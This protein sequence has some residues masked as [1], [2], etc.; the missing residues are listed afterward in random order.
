MLAHGGDRLAQVARPIEIVI[1]D[2]G[3]DVATGDGDCLVQTGAQ[4]YLHAELQNDPAAGL[5]QALHTGRKQTAPQAVQDQ[6]DL[7]RAV[8]LAVD[9]VQNVRQEACA[10]GDEDNADEGAG[11]HAA[12]VPQAAAGVAVAAGSR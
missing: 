8:I 10:P 11:G 1:V 9:Q 2:L 5:D 7:A 4:R 3:D 6:D 12:A